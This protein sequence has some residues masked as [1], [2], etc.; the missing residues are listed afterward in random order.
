MAKMLKL[1]I[2]AIL[3]TYRP[4]CVKSHRFDADGAE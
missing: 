4:D 3:V 2:L 1:I